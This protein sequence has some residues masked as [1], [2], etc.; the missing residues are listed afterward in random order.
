MT[1]KKSA[2]EKIG[3]SA[4]QAKIYTLL[5]QNNPLSPSDI[6]RLTKLHRPAVYAAVED[7]IKLDL[8]RVVPFGKNKKYMP[9]LQSILKNYLRILKMILIQKSIIYKMHTS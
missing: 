4:E 3:L 9:N 6:V 5:V 1:K 2:L 7:L 8:I